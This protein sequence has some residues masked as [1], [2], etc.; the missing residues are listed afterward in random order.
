MSKRNISE[1][2]LPEDDN[3]IIPPPKRS[4]VRAS[5]YPDHTNENIWAQLNNLPKFKPKRDIMALGGI[6]PY[7]SGS[8]VHNYL[9]KDPILDWL[10]TYYYSFHSDSTITRAMR[11]DL[12]TKLDSEN[13]KLQVLFD[14]G[15]DYEKKISQHFHKTYPNDIITINS[16]GRR[17]TTKAAYKRTI[18]AMMK[19]IPIIEQAVV[20]NDKWYSGSNRSIRLDKL[21]F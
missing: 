1:V 20:F 16:V 21:H 19:G 4:F 10:N 15:N 11:K 2:V 6:K 5:A 3:T 8:E 14:H 13:D 17:G 18:N 12:Q 9:L 7:V